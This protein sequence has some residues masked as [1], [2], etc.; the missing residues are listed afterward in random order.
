MSSQSDQSLKIEVTVNW[1]VNWD[2]PELL[3]GL[4]S[5][6]SLGLI[7][8]AQVRQLCQRYLSS[9]LPQ[10]AVAPSVPPVTPSVPEWQVE[11]PVAPTRR[12]SPLAQMWQSLRDEISVRWLL[13][14]GL[15]LVV[16]SSGVLAATQW[17]TFPAVGQYGVLWTYTLIFW[18]VSFWAGKQRNLQLTAQTLRL[19]M[20]LLIPVNFWAM[21]RLWQQPWGIIAIAFSAVSLTAITLLQR[22]SHADTP[23]TRFFYPSLLAYLGLSYLHWG[24]DWSNFPLLAVYIGMV[25]GTVALFYHTQ[26]QSQLLTTGEESPPLLPQG[27][28]FVIYALIVLLV[29]AVFIV[30]V[31]VEQLGL[32]IGFSGWL[33]TWLAQTR[34]QKVESL[35]LQERL[36]RTPFTACGCLLLV[37]GWVVSVGEPFPWQAVVVSGLGIGFFGQ[38]LRRFWRRWDLA[39]I[40]LIGLQAQWLIW[41]LLPSGFQQQAIAFSRQLIAP[42]IPTS[43]LLSLSLFPFVVVMVGLTDWLY[44]RHQ[45]QVARFGERLTLCLGIVLTLIALAHPSLRSLNLIMSTMTLW[46]I[47]YRRTPSTVLVYLTHLT[48]L[49]TLTSLVDWAFPSLNQNAWAGIL[50]GLMVA[51]WGFSVVNPIPLASSWRRSAWYLGFALSGLSYALFWTD[52]QPSQTLELSEWGLMWLATPLALT[53]VASRTQ[54]PQRQ[55]SAWLSVAALGAAQLLTLTL[56]GVRLVALGVATGLMGVN[57]RYLRR[58]PAAIIT[59]GLGLSF[60]AAMLWEGIPGLPRLTIAD[61]LIAGAIA[62]GVLWSLQRLLQRRN[63][64]VAALFAQACDAWAVPLGSVELLALTL[65]VTSL[66]LELIATNGKYAIAAMLTVAALLFNQWQQP[67]N[68]GVYSLSWAV[69]LTVAEAVYLAGGGRLDLAIASIGLGLLVLFVSDGWLSRHR[70][71]SLSSV[72]TLPL[73]YAVLGLLLR[74]GYFNAGTGL[75]TLGAALVGIGVGRRRQEWKPLTYLSI[76]GIS[77]AWYELT[78]Y[79]LLQSEGGSLADGITILAVIAVAI[80]FSYRLLAWFWQSRTQRRFLRLSATEITTTAHIHW[81]IGSL[82]MVSA[83]RVVVTTTTSPRLTTVGIVIFLLLAAYA[84]LQERSKENL[85]SPSPS[86][87]KDRVFELAGDFFPS[88]GWIYLGLIE[89][90][91]TYI[92]ARFIWTELAALDSWLAAI[93]CGIAV[94]MYHLPWERWGWSNLPWKRSAIAYPLLTVLLTSTAVSTVTLWVVVGFYSWLSWRRSDV[95]FTYVSIVLINWAVARWFE[96]YQL[97]DPLWYATLWGI[98]VLYVAQFDPSLQQSQRYQRRHYLRLLGTGIICLVALFHLD[99]GVIPAIIGIVAIF[100]G[101][102]LRVRAFLFLGTATFLLTAFYQLIILVF[103]ES[104]FKWVVALI[105]GIIFIGIAANFETRREQ[106]ALVFRNSRSELANWE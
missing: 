15:F 65:H 100:A 91:A 42:E 17:R 46:V 88:H 37:L 19:A 52:T 83:V 79:Q 6:L 71:L 70:P 51:E 35:S 84:L 36:W 96:Q 72:E 8:D 44:R 77:C 29:R 105:V 68:Q 1:D 55:Q 67:K 102:T 74:L 78:I 86:V 25:G 32:A 4:D 82:L 106:I 101:L 33:L 38:R 40:F 76:A 47:L 3:E 85:P 21:D 28:A 64:T 90:V 58:L 43:A 95:R 62:L 31:P 104:F 12:P 59:V 53:C 48:G 103:D 80:A 93:A 92:Y 45:P 94:L 56:P 69:G 7:G 75:I 81:L 41:E 23:F 2:Q 61:W 16:L 57:T 98:S 63:G 5:W 30:E 18:G 99:T 89:L 14:L 22:Q 24:W 27:R 10:V 87:G 13:F 66:E 26:Q 49:L 11:E 9:P 97:T 60:V 34:E 39:G 20:L 50:L 54:P 73:F